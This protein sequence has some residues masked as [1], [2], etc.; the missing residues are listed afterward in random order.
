MVALATLGT[1][2]T[3]VIAWQLSLLIT[4][5]FIEGSSIDSSWDS[6]LIAGLAGFAKAIVI[7]LQE[8]TSSRAAVRVKTELRA[9]LFTAISHLGTNWLNKKSIAELNLLATTGLDALEPYFSKYLP[10][11]V[12]TALVTPAL[13]IV[14]WSQDLLSAITLVATLP[15]I[16]VFMILIGWATR[17]IQQQQLDSLS[18]LTKHFLEVLRGLPTLRIFDRAK[19]QI[20]IIGEVSDEYRLKT[21][22]VLRVSFLSGFALELLASLSV[23]LI[24]VSIGLRLVDGQLSLLIGLF[25][26]LL[27]PEVYLPIRQV[28]THFHAAAEGATASQKVLDIIYDAKRAK[29]ESGMSRSSPS[30]KEFKPAKLNV[31]TGAS[32]AGKS[33]I[34]RRLLGFDGSAPTLGFKDVAWMPQKTSLLNGT[35][36]ENII[37]G[38]VLDENALSLAVSYAAL[39]DLKLEDQVGED[40]TLIS[41]GQA[42]RI[43]LARTF[44]RALTLQ[45]QYLLLD[46][47]VSALDDLRANQVVQSLKEFAQKGATVV[48]ISHQ[49]LLIDSADCTFEVSSAR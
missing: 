32:G 44:Y 15:L 35:V 7:W 1:F 45:T 2:S 14:V 43:A 41:G 24:A 36:Y 47:P 31:I 39:D 25:V 17:S 12:Y 42:Q 38:D 19:S 30:H 4:D 9:K 46:E 27:A 26:L 48:V 34:F 29:P 21:M 8:Y 16:P 5:I 6:F 49:K 18:K 20:Q 23:A 13:V 22:K 11:L 33:T 10:Q 3:V 28:G 40:S 37:G